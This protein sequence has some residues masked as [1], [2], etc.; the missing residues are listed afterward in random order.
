MSK[1]VAGHVEPAQVLTTRIRARVASLHLVPELETEPAKVARQCS[2]TGIAPVKL[3]I[4]LQTCRH[5]SSDRRV[6]RL[7]QAS[8]CNGCL[9]VKV[10]REALELGSQSE[11]EG[12]LQLARRPTSAGASTADRPVRGDE[13][14]EQLSPIATPPSE[15]S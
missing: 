8:E 11:K 9:L 7:G 14:I 6:V 5:N 13:L 15:R 4:R 2:L 12:P 10:L 3:T 1:T